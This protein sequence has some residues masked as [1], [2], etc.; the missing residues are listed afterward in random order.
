MS[1]LIDLKTLIQSSKKIAI[2]SHS[3]PDAD[4]ICS[5]LAL[6]TIIEHNFKNQK[7]VDI[8]IEMEEVPALY[9]EIIGD[10][11]ISNRRVQQYDL[12]ISLDCPQTN[13][14]KKYEELFINSL[15]TVNIDHHES[16]QNFA[17]LNFVAPNTSST[18]ELIYQM[19]KRMEFEI[20]LEAAKHI[21]T[22]I[23]T[24]TVCL[25]QSNVSKLTYKVLA[26]LSTM[27]FDQEAIKNHFFKTN[28]KAKTFLLE[29]ALSSIKFYEDDKIAIMQLQ[30][31]DLDKLDATKEDTLGIVEHANNIEGVMIAG[32]IIETENK[33]FYISLRSKGEMNV[34]EIAKNLGGGGH[35]NMAAFQYEGGLKELKLKLVEE[36]KTA[37]NQQDEITNE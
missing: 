25:S 17:M 20:P 16:N 28:T 12:A 4:A 21:F 15:N 26:E 31:R 34:S 30:K 1:N 35:T 10:T 37:L 5:S 36:C 18:G 7:L 23:L 11:S 6:K 22:C 19:A 33:E 29:K 2:F 27:D 3:M 13:R 32:I 9:E 14:F 24:D 8:F